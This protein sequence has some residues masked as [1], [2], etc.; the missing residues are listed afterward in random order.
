MY[1]TISRLLHKNTLH[2]EPRLQMAGPW[3]FHLNLRIAVLNI[4]GLFLAD[5]HIKDVY[6]QIE[7]KSLKK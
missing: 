6:I 3:H 4:V 7:Y 5:I 1:L 2:L